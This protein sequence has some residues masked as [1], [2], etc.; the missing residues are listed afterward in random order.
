MYILLLCISVK[1]LIL[2]YKPVFVHTVECNEQC[3]EQFIY[4]IL[5]IA[6]TRT[7]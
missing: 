1:Y 4:L 6:K 3:N 5:D 2:S 7:V